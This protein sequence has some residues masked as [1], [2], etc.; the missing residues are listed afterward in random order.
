M[1]PDFENVYQFSPGLIVVL[2]PD[3]RIVAVN[4]A[5]LK[6]AG[7]AREEMLGVSLFEL[8]PSNPGDADSDGHAILRSSLERVLQTGQADRMVDQRY[9]IRSTTSDTGEFVE[10]YWTSCELPDSRFSRQC[11]AHRPPG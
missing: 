10:R 1:I 6:A 2:D 3:F 4:K 5:Y 9:D 7:F 8:F 11:R